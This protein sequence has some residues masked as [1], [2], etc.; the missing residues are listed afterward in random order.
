MREEMVESKFLVSTLTPTRARSVQ[1][2][3]RGKAASPI[4]I[5]GEQRRAGVAR[6]GSVSALRDPAT[7]S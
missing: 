6:P 1:V 7:N 3:L 2:V 5:R 4:S